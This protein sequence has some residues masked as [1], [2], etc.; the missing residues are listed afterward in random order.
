MKSTKDLETPR[1]VFFL[2]MFSLQSDEV[3]YFNG[4]GRFLPKL[5]QTVANMY[6]SQSREMKN[7]NVQCN[8]LSYSQ[9]SLGVHITP[10]IL[11]IYHSLILLMVLKSGDH[12]LGCVKKS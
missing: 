9:L 10:Q 8:V 6:H 5:Q 3:L 4:G 7:W 2:A 12:H 11:V 1:R